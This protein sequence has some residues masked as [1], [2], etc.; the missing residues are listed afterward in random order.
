MRTKR[1]LLAAVAT[2]AFASPAWA[3]EINE[4]RCIL[5]H[6]DE[7]VIHGYVLGVADGISM[8]TDQ[9]TVDGITWYVVAYPVIGLKACFQSSMPRQPASTYIELVRK[10]VDAYPGSND[11]PLSYILSVVLVEAYPCPA[12][13]R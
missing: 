2:I 6:P 3:C 1:T 7:P 4:I 11:K 12:S 8:Q 9:K 10:F 5:D 13:L